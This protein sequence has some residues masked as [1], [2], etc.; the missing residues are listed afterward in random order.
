MHFGGRKRS[1]VETDFANLSVTS[2]PNPVSADYG[3]A[4][5]RS[6]N[7]GAQLHIELAPYHFKEMETGLARD[8][9]LT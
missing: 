6:L 9:S 8:R 7:G 4:P 3:S 2:D 1:D 5:P